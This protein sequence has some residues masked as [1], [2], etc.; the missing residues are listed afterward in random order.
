M[1]VADPFRPPCFDRPP[2][3]ADSYFRYEDFEPFALSAGA[4][5]EAWKLHIPRELIGHDVSQEDW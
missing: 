2:A 5:N 4:L 1:S 3:T